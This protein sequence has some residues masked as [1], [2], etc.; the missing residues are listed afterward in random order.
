MRLRH[1]SAYLPLRIRLTF[2]LVMLVLAVSAVAGV[3]SYRLLRRSLEAEAL[4]GLESADIAL[5]GSVAKI[6]KFKHDRLQSELKGVDLGC[7]V[8]GV[9]ARQCAFETI[10][11]FLRTEHGR[12]ARLHYGKG[13]TVTVGKFT[14]PSPPSAPALPSFLLDKEGRVYF[15][16]RAADAESGL[17]MEVEF[18]AADLAL[19]TSSRESTALV[20]GG[21]E[22]AEPIGESLGR[23]NFVLHSSSLLLCLDG[24]ASSGTLR[25]ADGTRYFVAFAPVIGA[26]HLC[27]VA[28]VPQSVVLAPANRWRSDMSVLGLV[29]VLAGILLAWLMAYLL[30][31]PLT[32]LRRRLRSFKNGDFDSP[33][34]IVG[35]GEILELSEALAQMADSVN[36]SRAALQ[37]GENRLRLAYKAAKL[38]MWEQNLVTGNIQWRSPETEK[39]TVED[40]S[41][42]Q[43]LR[44]VHPRDRRALCDAV[45]TAKL[46][47]NYEVEY[48]HIDADGT[49]TWIASWGKVIESRRGRPRTM[50]GVSMDITARKQAELIL[51]EQKKHV[52]TSEMAG[53]LAHEI[54]NPLTSV[55]GAIYMAKGVPGLPAEAQK[56]LAIAQEE[57]RRVAQIGRQIL[58]LYRKP[59]AAEIVDLKY[60]WEEVVGTRENELHEKH[61]SVAMELEAARVFGFPD[62]LRHAFASLLINAIESA[63]EG[64]TLHLR[65][66]N[67][68]SYARFGEKGARIIIADS[69]PGIA[70]D[71]LENAFEPFTGT[72]QSAGTGLG[73][74]ATRAAVLKHGGRIG[75]RTSTHGK[76][77]TCIS[78]YLPARC[79][80]L[81]AQ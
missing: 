6:L 75:V 32:L 4:D 41:F 47:G 14:D 81:S 64:S 16:L 30:S 53:T 52:A 62:E 36:T 26:E 77:G 49:S 2:A 8:S 11:K 43:L 42:R 55:I 33:V 63:P 50:L 61:L 37:E 7:G 3:S 73:L 58:S 46:T 59:G 57:S 17:A 21:A 28:M 19:A 12:A 68:H 45:R 74:W 79:T 9:M 71:R 54:N 48:R 27:S 13:R 24:K 69:G 5:S 23:P 31:R 66:H 38:W 25:E 65:V 39:T 51:I 70:G 1:R 35:S 76:T 78:V 60:L 80:S 10:R 18:D 44:E 56:F 72:K 40:G 34:P 15:T 67:S 29:A 22:R 20:A